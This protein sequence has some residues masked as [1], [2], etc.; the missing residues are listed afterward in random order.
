MINIKCLSKNH[1]F[2]VAVFSKM[3]ARKIAP[4]SVQPFSNIFSF[5]K[6]IKQDK[7]DKF[8]TPD[9]GLFERNM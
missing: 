9:E 6:Q 4:K 5:F 3:L 8:I 7:F 2:F 1:D